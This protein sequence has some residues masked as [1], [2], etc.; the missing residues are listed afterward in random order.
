MHKKMVIALLLLIFVVISSIMGVIWYNLDV[1]FKKN[2]F[3]W[4]YGTN[5]KVEA[6][7]LLEESNSSFS[8]SLK[9]DTIPL[10][11]GKEYPAVG[12][13]T[14]AVHY[15]T[16]WI[17]RVKE[18]RIIVKDSKAPTFTKKETNISIPYGQSD[19]DFLSHFSAE[20]LSGCQ[21]SLSV[22]EVDFTK[23]GK[24][25]AKVS[26]IDPYENK[27]EFSFQVE[28][29]EEKIVILEKP[30]AVE[31][32]IIS[33]VEPTYVN[34]ILVVN[35]KHP[36]DASYAPGENAE[37][38]ANVRAMIA[39]M[40]MLGLNVSTSYSGYRSYAYQN[41][42]YWSYVNSYG[43]A[44]ADTFSARAGYSEH[45]TGLAFDLLHYNGALIT[46]SAEANWIAN[47]AYRYGFIVR[48]QSGKESITGYQ[49]EPW[50]LRYVGNQAE[51][52]MRSGLTL[53]EYLGVAGGDY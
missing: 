38:G 33:K 36:L 53:E 29:E 1:T 41:Q 12:N 13:Y 44:A 26:A 6:K 22:E 47:N 50:H 40:Q 10:E 21:L 42:L 11:K 51:S 18:I 32:T 43:Q 48:Y 49:A 19:Y 9:I 15:Q 28:V 37:A 14:L 16:G 24:Y 39:E 31:N 2:T 34:G 4:E 27:T 46:A 25:N 30:K 35:K 23:A 20:D 52:I 17:H 5:G 7:D 45:Q 3:Y 8:S